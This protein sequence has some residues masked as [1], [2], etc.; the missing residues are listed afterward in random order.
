MS[1]EFAAL[2]VILVV[3]A[4]AQGGNLRDLSAT[5]AGPEEFSVVPQDPLQVPT[6]RT[7]LPVPTPGGMN[8][9]DRQPLL[10]A[11]VALGGGAARVG[12]DAALFGQ[13]NKFGT[14]PEIR[15]E[16]AAADARFRKGRSRFM[17]FGARGDRAYYGAYAGQSLDAAAEAARLSAA[18]VR[19][20]TTA[21]P[22]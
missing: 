1:K 6:S 15:A 19:V 21:P 3:S 12:G 9:A 10:D 5:D 4:C 22:R 18:G 8:L 17:L 14:D 7:S 11:A 2:C 13:L 16:L 20:P